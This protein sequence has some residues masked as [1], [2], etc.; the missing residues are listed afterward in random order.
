MSRMNGKKT[1][2]HTNLYDECSKEYTLVTSKPS[3]VGTCVRI[4][5]QSSHELGFFFTNKNKKNAQQVAL[6]EKDL[7]R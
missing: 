7:I 2:T 4:S 3:D 6:V 1:H 5:V